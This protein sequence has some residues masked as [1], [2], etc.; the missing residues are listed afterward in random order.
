ML[1]FDIVTISDN[2]VYALSNILVELEG[3]FDVPR[4]V[5][6]LYP[7]DHLYLALQSLQLT[8]YA[9][10]GESDKFY[11]ISPKFWDESLGII[12]ILS[13]RGVLLDNEDNQ[14]FPAELKGLKLFVLLEQ[15]YGF[16]ERMKKHLSIKPRK[17]KPRYGTKII[18][19]AYDFL[20]HEGGLTEGFT[21]AD[22]MRKL[23]A[24]SACLE[25]RPADDTLDRAIN[26]ALAQLMA[27]K[28]GPNEIG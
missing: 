17:P 3:L 12:P 8:A 5:N 19:K 9:R 16:L 22:C 13:A 20:E 21:R 28:R 24:W 1:S 6:G 18:E 25:R 11:S 26:K 27:T 7:E 14:T 23:R 15:A 10:I 4:D 2:R